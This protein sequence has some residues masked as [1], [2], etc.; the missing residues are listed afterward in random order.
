MPHSGHKH[1]PQGHKEVPRPGYQKVPQPGHKYLPWVHKMVPHPGHKMVPQLVHKNM[2]QGH[3]MVPTRGTKWCPNWGTF[4]C[5]RVTKWCP[6]PSTKKCPERGTKK[7]PGGGTK[8]GQVWFP[9]SAKLMDNCGA[10]RESRKI[11]CASNN[12]KVLLSFLDAMTGKKI[13]KPNIISEK[14]TEK[15]RKLRIK[16]PQLNTRAT[17]ERRQR[18]KITRARFQKKKERAYELCLIEN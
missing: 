6:D 13:M 4:T 18:K 16:R 8:P 9:V 1:M 10:L 14:K 5:P 11:L 17:R 15:Q 2:P 3:K 7:C 12:T